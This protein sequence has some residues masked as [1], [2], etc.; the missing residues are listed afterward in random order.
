[1]R[2]QFQR[3]VDSG[4]DVRKSVCRRLLGVRGPFFGFVMYGY[5]TYARLRL[6]NL[7]YGLLD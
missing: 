1:M 7:A 6:L 2:N 3:S 5:T 4:F